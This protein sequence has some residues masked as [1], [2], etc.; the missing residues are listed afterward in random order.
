MR[1]Y[2]VEFNTK[3]DEK[4]IRFFKK[5]LRERGYKF[6]SSGCF[7][8]TL[9]N[10]FTDENGLYRLNNLLDDYYAGEPV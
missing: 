9:I 1:W 3:K 8:N 2:G 5:Y 10:V 6:E 7:C 4:V